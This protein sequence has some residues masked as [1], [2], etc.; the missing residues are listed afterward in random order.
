[1]NKFYLLMLAFTLIGGGTASAQIETDVTNAYI[2]NADFEG[3][4]SKLANSGVSSDR[5]IYV[6][7]GWTV[8]YKNGEK[9]DMTALKVSDQTTFSNCSPIG[10][11]DEATYGKQTYRVRFRWGSNEFI[12]L[13]Q[14][15][16]LP[17]GNYTLSVAAAG[18]STCAAYLYAGD[19]KSTTAVNDAQ[20]KTLSIY[21][22]SDGSTATKLGVNIP[23]GKDQMYCA[24]DNFKLVS[25]LTHQEAY[26]TTKTGAE[27]VLN[28]D[29]YKVITGSERTALQ[30]AIDA[31]VTTTDDGYDA[32]RTAIETALTT[33]K[34]A[35]S[36]YTAFNTA[37]ATVTSVGTLP[38]A[39]TSTL[40]AL[41]AQ[42]A[43]PTS[44]SDAD[45]KTAA[46]PQA[47][48]AYVESNSVAGG[49][50][51]ATSYTSSITNP[52]A[53][54]GTNGWTK[55]QMDGGASI[56]VLSKEPFTDA[57]GSST[58]N[59]FD[60][61][62]WNSGDWTTKYEQVV[63]NL[64]AGKYLLAVT[65]R[66]S[67]GLRWYQLYG[68][69]QKVDLANINAGKNDG[70]F[71]RGW[72]D[73]Y[74]VFTTDGSDVTIGVTANA[75]KVHQWQS[76]TRF[77]LTRI[78]D[79]DAVTISE[80]ATEAPAA[81][82]DYVNVTLKRSFNANAWNTLVLPFDV[83]AD[84]VTS[85]FGSDTKVANFT[86]ASTD[87]NGDY[88]LNFATST[89]GIKAN[90]PVFIYGVSNTSFTFDGV[91]VA[92]STSLTVNNNDVAFTGF[93]TPTTATAGCF[94]I[95]SDNKFYKA[96]G[97]ETIKATRAVFTLPSSSSAKIASI[98]MDGT[99]TGITAVNS[100]AKVDNTVYNVA[101]QRV[102]N[103]YKG[104]VIVNGKKVLRK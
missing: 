61:G 18:N 103:S 52:N 85:V 88:T 77:R 59:Y 99:A 33:F 36:N 92:P 2:K 94:F 47:L 21:F 12:E 48:R 42:I 39:S 54:D 56:T 25:K 73:G 57:S 95:S 97:G 14:S 75:Q 19:V 24:F 13:S 78:G 50:T 9:N 41:N 82:K 65:A 11:L 35:L 101:G 102:N 60:G 34:A 72:N 51:G 53:D 100:N 80:D 87:A 20:W 38:Y 71:G 69:D 46:I 64:P 58:H 22:T 84:Q 98:Q 29:S 104:L 96:I 5:A 3:T 16:V 63:K 91:K 10:S 83:T 8:N 74:L 86:G 26:E 70:V 7:T 67:D 66:G 17:A 81:T 68:G 44:A 30:S 15:V 62:N 40:E 45:S 93:Y 27:A 43:D 49:V 32:A 1:M 31:T 55:A 6:P 23:R 89:D 79:L 90:T 76:F 37:K 4:Y 28:D